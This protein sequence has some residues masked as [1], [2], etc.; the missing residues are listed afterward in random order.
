VTDKM[1]APYVSPFIQI[2]L[3]IRTYMSA[4]VD[5][6]QDYKKCQRQKA[7][8]RNQDIVPAA[9]NFLSLQETCYGQILPVIIQARDNNVN[10][11]EHKP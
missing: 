10:H 4:L 1:S 7:L 6:V 3:F 11:N 8:Y 2:Y 9:G 5:I